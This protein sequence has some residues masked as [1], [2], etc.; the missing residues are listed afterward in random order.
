LDPGRAD[1]S[2]SSRAGC[3]CLAHPGLRA[4]LSQG[5]AYVGYIADEQIHQHRL[6]DLAGAFRDADRR[7]EFR[8][9][10]RS[11]SKPYRHRR[12]EAGRPKENSSIL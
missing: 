8:D 2:A 11:R 10:V 12:I 5:A 4:R 6:D 3:I 7:R 1:G 9:D